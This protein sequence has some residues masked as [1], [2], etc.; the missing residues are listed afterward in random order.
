MACHHILTGS[1]TA[2]VCT[3]GTSDKHCG[4]FC[5]ASA[6]SQ[7][8]QPQNSNL[9]QGVHHPLKLT[10]AHQ[11]SVLDPETNDSA[12]SLCVYMSK[13]W[14]LLATCSL[15]DCCTPSCCSNT[16]ISAV[17]L[18]QQVTA[19]SVVA[20]VLRANCAQSDCRSSGPKASC[21]LGGEMT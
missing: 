3:S 2:H 9:W 21:G 15:V 14:L 8:I 5:K 1:I 17:S 6:L 10:L 19:H 11:T 12:P 18:H 4:P 13:F 16:S 7:A 20:T